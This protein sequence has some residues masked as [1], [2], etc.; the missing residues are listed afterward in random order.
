MRQLLWISLSLLSMALL[1]SCESDTSFGTN[2]VP[3]LS[4][5][6][7]ESPEQGG[8]GSLG[9][10]CYNSE[11]GLCGVGVPESEC[12]HESETYVDACPANYVATCQIEG[13]TVYEYP[14]AT[15]TCEDVLSQAEEE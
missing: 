11:A 12:T 8:T 10:G 2:D 7:V 14:D 1:A 6:A 5:P 4:A 15:F 13:Y 9:A 3:V